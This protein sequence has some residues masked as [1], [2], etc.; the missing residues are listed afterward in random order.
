MSY[1]TD[2]SRRIRT[3]GSFE[4]CPY[5][6]QENLATFFRK[7]RELLKQTGGTKRGQTVCTVPKNDPQI[8][9]KYKLATDVKRI[10]EHI[11]G[12]GRIEI[13]SRTGQKL[14]LEYTPPIGR[15]IDPPDAIM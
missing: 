5:R 4:V 9:E 6:R 11:Q 14:T 15:L 8:Y 12:F 10:N 3:L 7:T 2:F 13:T 1:Q